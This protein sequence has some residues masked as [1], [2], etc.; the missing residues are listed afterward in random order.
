MRKRLPHWFL[1]VALTFLSYGALSIYFLDNF[2]GQK[3]HTVNMLNISLTLVWIF[4]NLIMWGFFIYKK[5]E[6]EAIIMTS[7]YLAI[8]ILNALN[9]KFGW[10]ISYEFHRT[11]SMITK[12]LELGF[13]A[14]VFYKHSKFVSSRGHGDYR[15]DKQHQKE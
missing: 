9:L 12:I 1:I 4:F 10:I 14:F 11:A 8:N 15:R 13:I 5:Y 6:N 7:Y 2:T 3:L